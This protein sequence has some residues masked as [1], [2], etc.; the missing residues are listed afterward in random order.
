MPGDI[1]VLNAGDIIPADCLILE[2]RDLFVDEATLTGETF[3]V[4]KESKVLEAETPLGK[5]VNSLWIGTSVV[6][7]SADVVTVHIGKETEFGKVSQRLRA[8]PEETEFEKGV[9]RFGYFLSEVTLLMVIAIFVINVF[10]A[11]PYLL[12]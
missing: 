1:V 11:R 6:S 7:G 5:H 3:P 9:L 2:S 10:L 8:R 12:K 4:E